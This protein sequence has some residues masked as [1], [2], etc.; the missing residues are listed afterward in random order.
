MPVIDRWLGS[1]VAFTSGVKFIDQLPDIR[2]HNEEIARSS[3][4]GIP[5]RM[6][7]ATRREH[8]CPSRSLDLLVAE[9]ECQHPLKDIPRLIIGV[10]DM[11]RGDKARWTHRGTTIGPFS[12]HER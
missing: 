6:R 2:R 1:G 11:R 4:A 7:D 5:V 10:M 3:R 9:A 12:N 8:G